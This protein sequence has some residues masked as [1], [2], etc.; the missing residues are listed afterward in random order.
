[1]KKYIL[2]ATVISVLSNCWLLSAQTSLVVSGDTWKYHNG[3]DPGSTWKDV[4]FN[5]ASWSSG[6]SEL[7]YGDGDEATVIPTNYPTSY[8][9]RVINVANPAIFTGGYNLSV[10]RDDGIVVYINGIQVYSENMP[11][12]PT[13]SSWST[14][15]CAD[16]GN[17]WLSTT[18]T[19]G[20]LLTGNNTIA[21]EVHQASA[22]SSDVTFDL[23]MQGLI[24][25]P[26]ATITRG[27]YIQ[28][29]TTT[30]AILSMEN[31]QFG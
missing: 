6:P 1:M 18:L 22:G 19:L 26:G 2:F 12:S 14:A 21:V 23:Q 8:F 31:Q 20:T 27:P 10:L 9:R 25:T 24:G 13:Y 7:G 15:T 4:G 16:D 29:L 30:S 5:D 28:T 11:A 3:S 17:T